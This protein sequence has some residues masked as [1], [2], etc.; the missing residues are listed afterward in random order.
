V[1]DL[2]NKVMVVG[3]PEIETLDIVLDADANLEITPFFDRCTTKV[4]SA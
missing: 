2:P 1:P 4:M 3:W